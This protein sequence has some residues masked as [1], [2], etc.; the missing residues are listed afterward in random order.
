[1]ASGRDPE[2]TGE[3][4]VVAESAPAWP[5]SGEILVETPADGQ[6]VRRAATTPAAI[7][8]ATRPVRPE[9]PPFFQLPSPP[10][11]IGRNRHKN[12]NAASKTTLGERRLDVGYAIG[13]PR[14]VFLSFRKTQPSMPANP[15]DNLRCSLRREPATPLC[16]DRRGR[17]ASIPAGTLHRFKCC[18]DTGNLVPW[19]LR[20]RPLGRFRGASKGTRREPDGAGIQAGGARFWT[21]GSGG[22]VTGADRGW[23]YRMSET[24]R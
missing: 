10:K 6:R 2:A 20:K 16:S 11:R 9:N 7:P 19:A 24:T 14:C 5:A 23:I 3:A 15:A 4:W 18:D 1:M 12:L 13:S 17:S 8:A 21:V 22:W